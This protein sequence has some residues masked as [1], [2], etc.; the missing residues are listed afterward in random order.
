MLKEFLPG[1]TSVAVLAVA[2]A[3]G[4]LADY[5]RL[6]ASREAMSFEVQPDDTSEF[7]AGDVPELG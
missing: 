7:S 4:Y 1:I 5:F 3:C 6:R 2:F